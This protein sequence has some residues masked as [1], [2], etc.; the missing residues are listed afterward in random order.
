MKM[1][2]TGKTSRVKITYRETVTIPEKY[3][4]L[5]WD[6]KENTI[7]E[8]Y[9]LRI[10]TYGNLEDIKEVYNKYPEE[11]FDITFKYPEIKRG[12]KFWIKRWKEQK[13]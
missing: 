10:L 6:C 7:L 2:I 3:K 4:D 8:K 12:V 9:I 1:I 5:F 11:T 13:G